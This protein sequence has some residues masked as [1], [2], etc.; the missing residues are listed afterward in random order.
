MNGAEAIVEAAAARE[1]SRRERRENEERAKAEKNRLYAQD[2]K[3]LLTSAQSLYPKHYLVIY[4][5]QTASVTWS[6]D[7]C[8]LRRPT[9]EEHLAPSNYGWDES[10]YSF[11]A[12]VAQGEMEYWH[13]GMGA[14][15]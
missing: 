4:F 1:E 7:T 11:T 14:N 3:H 15:P 12:V 6:E 10:W 13:P 5:A 8:F 9:K 2:L